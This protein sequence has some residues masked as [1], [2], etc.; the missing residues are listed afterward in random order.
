MT[1]I[2]DVVINAI[3]IRA[4][5]K[6][7]SKSTNE[8]RKEYYSML[9]DAMREHSN[10]GE[11]DLVN[12]TNL[13]GNGLAEKGFNKNS[14]KVMRSEFRKIWEHID[15]VA[16]ETSSWKAALRDIRN[17]TVPESIRLMDD[18]VA[19]MEAIEKLQATLA[20]QY[21]T[22]QGCNGSIVADAITFSDESLDMTATMRKAA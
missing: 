3:S 6:D 10:I 12:A 19:T 1:T 7:A 16:E 13:F 8:T 18:M 9:F 14:I 15:N 11:G 4:W 17:A 20:E 2:R 22:W 21:E 5:E